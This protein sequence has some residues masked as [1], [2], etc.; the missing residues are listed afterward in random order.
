[1]AV[2][3]CTVL[4]ES[5]TIKQ[6]MN[7]YVMLGKLRENPLCRLKLRKPRP[8]PQPVLTPSQVE[9]IAAT[10][11]PEWGEVFRFLAATGLRSSE[12]VWLE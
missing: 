12:L 8:I 11:R 1:M 5:E 6:L 10:A 7:H 3:A 4:L 2:S 9:K